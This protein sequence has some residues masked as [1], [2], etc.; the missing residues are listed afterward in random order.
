MSSLP[1]IIDLEN[2]EM[3]ESEYEEAIEIQSQEQEQEQEVKK[4]QI[5]FTAD[6]ICVEQKQQEVEFDNESADILRDEYI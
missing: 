5:D 2:V 6:Y 4:P 3:V 1:K